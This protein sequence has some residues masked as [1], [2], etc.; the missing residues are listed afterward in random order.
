MQHRFATVTEAR[1]LHSSNLQAATQFV[2]DE[3]RQGFALN[4][5]GD[6][7]KRLLGLDHLLEQRHHRLKARQFLLVQQDDRVFQL[8]SHLVGVGD[9]IGAQVATVELHAFDDIGLCFQTFVLFDGDDTFVADFLHRVCDLTADLF[10]AIGGDGADLCDFV[11][12][13]YVTGSGFDRFDDR[14]SCQIDTALQVHRVHASGNRFHA[15][16]DDGLG[17]NS[18]GGGAVTCFVVGPGSNFLDHLCAH[19]F[20]L[21]FQFDFLRHGYT[22]FGDAR[23][24]EG[25]VQNH[26]PAFGAECDFHRVGEDVYTLEHPVAGIGVKFDVLS[27]HVVFS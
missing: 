26:V 20:E 4:V 22:V 14:G 8:D 1:C 24:A 15:F 7:Q 21:V 18:R 25:F 5:F 10:F 6:D 16:F 2:H 27:S 19:V 17:Q 9:E 11:A 23:C 12:V 3:C 13:G